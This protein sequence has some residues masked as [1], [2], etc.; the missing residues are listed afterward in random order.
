M[1]I[2]FKKLFWH[3][4]LMDVMENALITFSNYVWNQ[5]KKHK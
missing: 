2:N 3:N 4:K 5:R 1:K